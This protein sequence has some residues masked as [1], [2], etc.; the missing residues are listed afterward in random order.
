MSYTVIIPI[1]NEEKILPDL[2]RSLKPISVNN[3]I[4]II[5][6]GSTDNSKQILK[7][8]DFINLYK[9]P[10]NLGKGEAI[11]LGIDKAINEKI[12]ISDWDMEIKPSYLKDIMILN[13]NNNIRFVLGNRFD[14]IN[15]LI[16]I[17]NF[18]NYA[19]TKLFNFFH[20][21]NFIDALSCAKAFYK[22][23]VDLEK[24][25]ASGFDIDVE[26]SIHLIRK[27]KDRNKIKFVN[28][29]Y[30]RR[31][32]KEGKKLKLCDGWPILLKILNVK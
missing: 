3:E 17:W 29:P 8:C 31:T 26:L 5:N 18:G 22:K 14:Y 24:L 11:K 9:F 20:N 1:H 25:S 27:I 10:K 13:E 2:L 16:S 15:P 21:A 6:D 19:F 12:I 28:I 30:E 32:T 7:K 23:D 4:L